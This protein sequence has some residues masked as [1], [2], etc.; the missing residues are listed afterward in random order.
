V[1]ESRSESVMSRL[2]PF[3][4]DVLQ[5]VFIFHFSFPVPHTMTPHPPSERSEERHAK[6]D[7]VIIG[8][9]ACG[10]QCGADLHDNSTLSF[11]ILEA[12]DRVGGR[13]FTSTERRNKL[14]SLGEE[15]IEF[16]RDH[17]ASWIH[18]LGEDGDQNPIV[19]LLRAKAPNVDDQICP[20]FDGNPW[21][22]PD[23][24]LHRKDAIA[25]YMDRKL[26]ANESFVVAEGIRRHYALRRKMSQYAG[27]L[28]DSGDGMKTVH[29]SLHETREMFVTK[30][31]NQ[32]DNKSES[33]RAVEKIYPF[34]NFLSEN[35]K[36]LSSTELQLSSVVKDSNGT[37][38]ETD[39]CYT[40]EGDY[41]GAHCKIKHGFSSV[42]KPLTSKLAGNITLRERVTKIEWMEDC[43]HVETSSGLTVK[44][45]CCVCTIPL[46]CLKTTAE[47][48]FYPKLTED[49]L[50]AI[51]SVS[52]GTYK[53]VFLTF[54]KIFWPADKPLIGL[55]RE[56]SGT[57][58]I[59]KYLLVNNL[60]A[61]DGIP[62]LEAVLCGD[63]GKWAFQKTDNTIK[64]YVLEFLQDTMPVENLKECC[65]DC[66]ITR[67]EEDHLTSG[68]YSSFTLGTLERHIDALGCSEWDGR[69]K[70]AG[71]ATE[72]E[73]M[74]SVHAALLSGKRASKYTQAF[75]ARVNEGRIT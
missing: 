9:G 2:V 16:Y 52:A 14:D 71:E 22:R 73:H 69:L 47:S 29:M 74:G 37:S 50:E 65:I 58:D 19:D 44:A 75:I 31:T 26:I 13:I 70:F 15:K 30:E 40:S 6:V 63:M 4:D 8:A 24:V 72:S 48:M 67:W 66:H 23:S 32:V 1:F 11:Q 51:R 60:W 46:G 5:V 38:M 7:V 18:G 28:Y 27:Q 17:G 45:G 34:Y 55:L 39:E 12:R 3:V 20:V 35:W 53:K 10:L 25:I 61:K 41:S 54:K 68:S 62:C 21:T 57:N 36:G 42:I 56:Q 33:E 49:K 59:G 64:D 43:V